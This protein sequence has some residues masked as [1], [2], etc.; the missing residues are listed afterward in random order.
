M[1]NF[2]I[3]YIVFLLFL[4]NF[5]Y[6]SQH[7]EEEN[8]LSVGDKYFVTFQHGNKFLGLDEFNGGFCLLSIESSLTNWVIERKSKHSG[9]WSVRYVGSQEVE[10]FYLCEKSCFLASEDIATPSLNSDFKFDFYKEGYWFIQSA[11]NAVYL[12]MVPDLSFPR[13]R[14]GIDNLTPDTTKLWRINLRN[15]NFSMNISYTYDFYRLREGD[16]KIR[17][18]HPPQ[19]RFSFSDATLM[20]RS[21]DYK[22]EEIR[23]VYSWTFEETVFRGLLSSCEI[24]SQSTEYD[25]SEVESIE[26]KHPKARMFLQFIDNLFSIKGHKTD[27]SSMLPPERK[28]LMHGEIS[29]L[30]HGRRSEQQHNTSCLLS[31]MFNNQWTIQRSHTISVTDTMVIPANTRIQVCY[32]EVS[33]PYQVPF[34]ARIMV[35]SGRDNP[36]ALSL[37]DIKNILAIDGFSARV[38]NE[39]STGIEYEVSGIFEGSDSVHKLSQVIL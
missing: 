36:Y 3:L 26:A 32:Q 38:I 34:S 12:T 22:M 27:F 37:L 39:S 25:G 35:T 20:I 14:E 10:S 21:E 30:M 2:K 7:S 29:S 24:M 13:F 18:L 19:E 1:T 5:I 9:N 8:F 6:C 31:T 28:S 33:R 23:Q 16:T 4:N 15:Y 11:R 17:N